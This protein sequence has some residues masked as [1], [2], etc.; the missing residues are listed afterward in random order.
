[1]TIVRKALF[2]AV[3]L[4]FGISSAAPAFAAD[5]VPPPSYSQCSSC[6]A[7]TSGGGHS[8]GPNLHGVFG[9]KVGTAEGYAYSPQA[10]SAGFVWTEDRLEALIKDPKGYKKYL[11]KA[12]HAWKPAAV[13]AL[14]REVIPFLCAISPAKAAK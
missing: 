8:N 10:K 5:P 14:E 11:R 4:G 7:Y 12:F 6:H 13:E 2:N 1:M 9:R 3:V